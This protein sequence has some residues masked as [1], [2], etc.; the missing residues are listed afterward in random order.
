MIKRIDGKSGTN[1]MVSH[2]AQKLP[3]KSNEF[4][5]SFDD[6]RWS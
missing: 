1:D 5:P 3:R 4:D 6:G 2:V